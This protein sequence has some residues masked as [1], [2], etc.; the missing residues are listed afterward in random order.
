MSYFR[1][2]SNYQ[3]SVS[4]STIARQVYGG[5][6][7][8][9]ITNSRIDYTPHPLAKKVIYEGSFYVRQ[10]SGSYMW[11]G[12]GLL[13]YTNG[14]WSEISSANR[15]Q[16]YTAQYHDGV[17]DEYT[18]YFKY[19][20]NTW[21]GERPIKM[22]ASSY[23]SNWKAI[24]HQTSRWEGGGTDTSVMPQFMMYSVL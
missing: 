11:L 18:P 17:S 2:T 9:D 12:I 15:R 3:I 10:N 7:V 22:V 14:S 24:F 1:Q 16:I 6:S 19:S 8:I 4:E 20:L 21:Q 5:G 13:H 23:S